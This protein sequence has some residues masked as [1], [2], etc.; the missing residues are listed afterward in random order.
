MNGAGKGES[1]K[2]PDDPCKGENTW[3][4]QYNK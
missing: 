3:S 4:F 1:L 2:N